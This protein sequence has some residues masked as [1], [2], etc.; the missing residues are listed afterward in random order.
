VRRALACVL[1]C[2]AC[3]AP[4]VAPRANP[5]PVASVDAADAPFR[6]TP[7]PM[8]DV[9]FVPP[10][11]ESA[12]L[13]NG[14]R[15]LLVERRELP[16]VSVD[17]V[18]RTGFADFDGDAEAF[19]LMAALLEQGTTTRS[20]A[21]LSDAWRAIAA[22]HRTWVDF[23]SGGAGVKV[24]SSH[25]DA[26]LA[27]L[28][29]VLL[30][31]AF[32]DDEIEAT[33]ARWI[34]WA[35]QQKHAIERR[36]ATAL[37]ASVYALDHPYGRTTLSR[38]DA[39]AKLS[40]ADVTRA[41]AREMTP[42]R[43][44]IVVAGDTSLTE[45]LPRLEKAFGSWR[46]TSA[47]TRVIAPPADTPARVVL[48]DVR[49]A[50]P[51][52]FL[53]EPGIAY[54]APDRHAVIVMNEILGGAYSSRIFRNLRETHA[55]TY[56]AF[57]TF[58]MRHGPGP[59]S[60]GGSIDVV[61]VGDSIREL[62]REVN[63]MRDADV[64]AEELSLAKRHLVLSQPSRF[65]AASDVTRAL[66][67]IVVHELPLDDWATFAARID[68]VTIEDV[69]RAANAHLHPDRM[70]IIVT[71]ERQKLEPMLAPFGSIEVRDADGAIVH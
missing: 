55:W 22:D 37:A 70:K 56:G 42:T 44:Q 60:A 53:A 2:A 19:L 29:D 32:A 6:A 26:A 49:T 61:H 46:G 31:P 59:F 67:T 1:L 34:A 33:R 16:V 41:Y 39:L 13:S 10:K 63:A 62:L 71:G 27:L 17:V 45:I 54:S 47:P 48:A 30:R 64:S 3:G 43:A 68:A 21:Q 65:E 5:P 9:P 28:A 12:T 38:A 52:V 23:D 18:V 4:A 8:V 69:R 20:A 15:V 66:G 50:Q 7:P 24:L 11:I 35:K 51:R 36:A 40:R 14:M 25:L 57:S 58:A